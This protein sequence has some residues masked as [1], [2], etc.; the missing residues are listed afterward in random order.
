[1]RLLSDYDNN[2]ILPFEY[3]EVDYLNKIYNIL[4]K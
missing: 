3:C 1:M 2:D 4:N